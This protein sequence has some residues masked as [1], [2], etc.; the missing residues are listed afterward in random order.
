MSIPK[1]QE[2]IYTQRCALAVALARM[3][4]AAGGS[5]GVEWKDDGEWPALYIDTEAGQIS[6]HIS[7]EDQH[8]LKGLPDYNKGWDGKYTGRTGEWCLKLSREP[9]ARQ[10]EGFKE[11]DEVAALRLSPVAYR[12]WQIEAR[13]LGADTDVTDGAVMAILA[14]YAKRWI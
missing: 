9:V 12:R 3:T 2:T 1:S 7:D 11:L 5:A 8:L 4:L 6:Y 14:S 10:I 13:K